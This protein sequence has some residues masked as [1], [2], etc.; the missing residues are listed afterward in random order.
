MWGAP[1]RMVCPFCDYE[2]LAPRVELR[3]CG[4][5]EMAHPYDGI[6]DCSAYPKTEVTKTT[7]RYIEEKAK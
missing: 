6:I 3:R 5:E 7:K 1:R 4:H 2:A